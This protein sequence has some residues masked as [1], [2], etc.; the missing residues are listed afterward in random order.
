MADPA[1]P[2]ILPRNT[3]E[4][5]TSMSF[6]EVEQIGRQWKREQLGQ[7]RQE[8]P[9]KQVLPLEEITYVPE[10][11]QHATCVQESSVESLLAF[12]NKEPAIS[13]EQA[14][15]VANVNPSKRGTFLALLKH[16]ILPIDLNWLR[17]RSD[18]KSNI[19]DLL[20][21]ERENTIDSSPI[22]QPDVSVVEFELPNERKGTLISSNIHADISDTP[23]VEPELPLDR[24]DTPSHKAHIPETALAEIE[25]TPGKRGE[26]SRG[27]SQADTNHLGNDFGQLSLVSPPLA[28]F[29]PFK[30]LPSELRLL[31]W[32]LALPEDTTHVLVIDQLELNESDM[33]FSVK[34]YNM[35]RSADVGKK[36]KFLRNNLALSETCIDSRKMFLEKNPYLSPQCAIWKSPLRFGEATTIH[37]PH[38]NCFHSSA[39]NAIRIAL[40]YGY[41]PDPFF[42]QVRKLAINATYF[43]DPMLGYFSDVELFPLLA[44]FDSLD[45]LK[46]FGA[47][48]PFDESDNQA[49]MAICETGLVEYKKNNPEYKLPTIIYVDPPECVDVVSE[50]ISDS[51]VDLFGESDTDE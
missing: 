9:G 20:S 14:P 24:T 8:N 22:V 29:H 12:Q 17:S 33:S 31:I 35:C 15:E 42:S 49:A 51:E 37:I 47:S 40:Q 39:K 7:I 3:Y 34:L 28:E 11:H 38:L 5:T 19:T 41:K 2:Q 25:I 13:S 4:I 26:S 30:R 44:L 36:Y 45:V 1:A 21:I 32:Q 18:K 43:V 46:I 50:D 27:L 16:I 6:R 23:I 48:D 10:D